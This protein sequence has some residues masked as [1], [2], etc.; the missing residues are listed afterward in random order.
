MPSKM[1]VI[2]I[3]RRRKIEFVEK[4]YFLPLH[5]NDE[6]ILNPFLNFRGR[7]LSALST[8]SGGTDHTSLKRQ[9]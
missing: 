4:L 9:S 7:R 3:T 6:Q 8:Q 2:G 5:K 1:V